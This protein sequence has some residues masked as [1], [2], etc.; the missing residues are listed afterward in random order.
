MN[1]SSKEVR[2]QASDGIVFDLL[3]NCNNFQHYVPEIRNWQSTE[4][5]CRFTIDGI[6]DIQMNITEKTANSHILFQVKNAQIN[7]LSITFDI[8]NFSNESLLCGHASLDIPIFVAQMI[9]SSIQ[10]FLDGLVE[11][12]KISVE[13]HSYKAS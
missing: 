7:A 1:I 9:K 10:K 13:T 4:N 2:I 12:I 6:G 8:K 3:S 5:T 11:R